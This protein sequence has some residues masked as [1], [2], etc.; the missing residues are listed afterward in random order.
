MLPAPLRAAVAGT[1]HGAAEWLPVSSSGHVALLI[2]AAGWPE[3][4]PER[5]LERRA[6]EVALHTG[7]IAP[8]AWR[9]WRDVAPADRA[10]AAQ[11]GLLA[12][13]ATAVVAQLAGPAVEQRLAGPSAIAS[14]LA[15][16]SLGLLASERI[17]ARRT[18]ASDRPIASATASDALLLGLAQSAAIVPGVSR[19]ASTLAA[20]AALGY[21]PQAASS[22]SWAAGL[23]TLAAATAWQFTR[24]RRE[25]AAAP[26]VPLA[27]AT[28]S[29]LAGAATRELPVRTLGVPAAGWT[30]WRLALAAGTLR[31]A[32]SAPAAPLAPR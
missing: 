19:R 24:A 4:A 2:E 10:R 13:A 6:L 20:A 5:R 7:S 3:A 8:L 31:R 27:G 18:G 21:S 14:G 11:V 26:L 28:A 30:A 17:G 23:P 9:L 16:G 1:L 15:A 22:L 25:L 32:R 29:L 12:T